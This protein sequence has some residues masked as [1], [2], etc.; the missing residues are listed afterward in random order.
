MG[1]TDIS[2]HAAAKT[3]FG[4]PMKPIDVVKSA[5]YRANRDYGTIFVLYTCTETMTHDS[6]R[7]RRRRSRVARRGCSSGAILTRCRGAV[8]SV[9]LSI[10]LLLLSLP[11][12]EFRGV[13]VI[14]VS[15]PRMPV[16]ACIKK[17]HID[18]SDQY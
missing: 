8:L 14:S 9:I 2:T 11:C 17:P 4:Q 15:G 7:R 16:R 6:S 13:N 1:W 18:V 12:L 10:L 3:R 5:K